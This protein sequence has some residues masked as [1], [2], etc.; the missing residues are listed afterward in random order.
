MLWWCCESSAVSLRVSLPAHCVGPV[1]AVASVNGTGWAAAAFD[2]HSLHPLRG[3][4]RRARGREFGRCR[5]AA[6]PGVCRARGLLLRRRLA[7]HGVH[8]AGAPRLCAERAELPEAARASARGSGVPGCDLR[9]GQA[10]G[11]VRAAGRQPATGDRR[12]QPTAARPAHHPNRPGDPGHQRQRCRPDQRGHRVHQRPAAAGFR[13]RTTAGLPA[14]RPAVSAAV[15]GERGGHDLPA[16]R[17]GRAGAAAA[18]GR[19]SCP[20][21]ARRDR[22]GRLPELRPYGGLFSLSA[23]AQ[24]GRAVVPCQARRAQRH[25][26]P[27]GR[28]QGRAVRGHL[29][30]N[31]RPRRLPAAGGHV[32]PRRDP[33]V[34]QPARTGDPFPPNQL[35]ADHQ[36]QAVLGA[37][38]RATLAR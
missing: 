14:P 1:H 28:G 6:V 25:D 22:A 10:R 19:H 11:H 35:G 23:G 38:G 3:R 29:D 30:R 33:V 37:L 21:P 16:D 15:C 36:A 4:H 18:G 20:C 8:R 31:W 26:R 27:G 2:A 34:G 7:G 5:L 24:R 13:A 9:L 12:H 17:A 32:G